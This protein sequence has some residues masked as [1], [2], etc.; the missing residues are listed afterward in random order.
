MNS[1]CHCSRHLLSARA[2][3]CEVI[4]GPASARELMQMRIL[5]PIPTSSLFSC[6]LLLPEMRSTTCRI[7]VLR[8]NRNVWKRFLLP[9]LCLHILAL[10][11]PHMCQ[12]F[13]YFSCTPE[14]G[15]PSPPPLH[16]LQDAY[17]GFVHPPRSVRAS[18]VP[19]LSSPT[20]LEGWRRLL[21]TL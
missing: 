17:I 7:T 20:A 21:T 2:R 6:R 9:A 19:R 16:C 10:K 8:M 3:A 14:Y 4:V 12:M 13:W 5:L 18:P 11:K 1:V 15:L